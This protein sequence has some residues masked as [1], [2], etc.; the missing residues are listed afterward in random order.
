MHACIAP[1][2]RG[3]HRDPDAISISHL[4]DGDADPSSTQYYSNAIQED[5]V[6]D[7]DSSTNYSLPL[8]TYTLYRC[9]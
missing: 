2:H 4:R 7:S 1:S 8:R 6:L 5:R 3:T 9:D